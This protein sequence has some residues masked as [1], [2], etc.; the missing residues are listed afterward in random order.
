LRTRRISGAEALLR[1]R[2]P[3]QG[4]LTPDRFVPLANRT[5]LIAEIGDW[6]LHQAC[7][8][9]RRWHKDGFT[10][11]GVSVNLSA[12]QLTDR[13]A[14]RRIEA[15]L[16]STGL[17]ARFLDLETEEAGPML[18]EKRAMDNL[19]GLKELGAK[20]SLDNFGTGLVSLPALGRMPID[21]LKI[22]RSLVRAAAPGAGTSI[23]RTLTAL[24][25]SLDLG[26][27]AGGVETTEQLDLMDR[28][29]CDHIQGYLLSK[30]QSPAGILGLLHKYNPPEG[31]GPVQCPESFVR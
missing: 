31:D 6:V 27:V 25:K 1:W 11:L 21:A 18:D 30:P 19:H 16:A 17:A 24:G 5:G 20:L 3:K 15:A 8:Q 10:Q 12:A 29:G 13:A 9:A 28:E 22:D 7:A 14:V 23:L 2:H 26:V 4:T